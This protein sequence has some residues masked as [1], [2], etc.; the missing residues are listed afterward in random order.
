[1]T[2]KAVWRFGAN[3]PSEGDAGGSRTHF[4]RVAAGCRAVW[5]QRRDSALA[6]NRTWSSTFAG[7][8]ASPAHPK[9]SVVQQPAEES[10][11]VLQNRSLPCGPA[12]SQAVASVA[13]PGIEPG[14]TASEAAVLSGTTTG[15]SV[16]STPTGSRTRTKTFA[17]SRAVRYTIG[18]IH[19]QGRRLDLH[20]HEP[21]YKVDAFLHR[22][23]SA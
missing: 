22:A 2:P 16:V 19:T 13:R 1:M 11:P 21:A 9:D 20:Q 4:D 3:I 14:P 17:A 15:H 6:R 7:S 5:L 8:R 23:T 10:N 12:H 18:T